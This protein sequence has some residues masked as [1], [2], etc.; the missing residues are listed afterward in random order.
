[1]STFKILIQKARPRKPTK[2]EMLSDKAAGQVS[3]SLLNGIQRFKKRIPKAKLIEAIET[4]SLG[5][6]IKVIPWEENIN[7]LMPAF[8]KL[9]MSHDAAALISFEA[10][11]A[12]V[13]LNLRTDLKN[14]KYTQFIVE[15]F[16]KYLLDLNV[17]AQEH[18][19]RQIMRSFSHAKHPSEVADDIIDHIGLNHRQSIA[20]TNY[21]MGLKEKGVPEA[22]ARRLSD[23]YETRL[24]EQRSIMIAR[25]EIQNANNQGQLSVWQAAQDEG[26]LDAETTFKIW[27]TD[28]DPCPICKS[29]KGKKVKLNE[30]WLIKYPNGKE[31]LADVPSDA[32]PHCYCYSTILFN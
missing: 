6:I 26:L 7:N 3:A 5:H 29:M 30:K 32:H 12:P 27:G 13:Q 16:N 23:D 25:T 20:L 17:E 2:L 1:M 11:P 31:K 9:K 4:K 14:P 18:I 21:Q 10:L 22:Q 19:Q 8:E 28:R 15:R 24:L